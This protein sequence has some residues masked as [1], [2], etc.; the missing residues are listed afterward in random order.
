MTVPLEDEAHRPDGPGS[1]SSGAQGSPLQVRAQVKWFDT[2]HGFGFLAS[3]ELPGDILIHRSLLLEH[4]RR[5]IAEGAT[6]KCLVCNEERGLRAT[7]ILSI[8]LSTVVT[9]PPERPPS[10]AERSRTSLLSGAG[11]LETVRVKWFDRLKGYGFL[12]RECEEVDIFVHI[13]TLRRGG[14]D[15]IVPLQELRAR[16][17]AG[18]KGPLAVEVEQP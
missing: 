8:D 9:V 14:L 18:E 7:K 6:L 15:H 17:A 12:N 11:P 10:P 16:I 1:A 5:S 13:E 4:R 2:V 3:G